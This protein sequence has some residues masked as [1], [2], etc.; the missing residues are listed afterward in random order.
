MAK[1]TKLPVRPARPTT[2]DTRKIGGWTVHGPGGHDDPI[3]HVEW[4]RGGEVVEV[5][6]LTDQVENDRAGRPRRVRRKYVVDSALEG[7]RLLLRV[8]GHPEAL[9]TQREHGFSVQFPATRA[10]SGHGVGSRAGWRDEVE[11]PF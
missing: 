6:H 5:I 4:S 1:V 2:I 9:I 3:G 7:V 11:I 10:C 8:A